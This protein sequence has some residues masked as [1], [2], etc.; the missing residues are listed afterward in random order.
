MKLVVPLV[1]LCILTAVITIM[2]IPKMSATGLLAI[3]SAI[4]EG[5]FCGILGGLAGDE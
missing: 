1:L 3:T 5:Y 4:L 2:T